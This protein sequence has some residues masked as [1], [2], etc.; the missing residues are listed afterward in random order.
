MPAVSH[1][2]VTGAG[3]AGTATATGLAAAGVA[4]DLIDV[5]P[6]ITAIGSGITMQGNGLRE[7]RRLGVSTPS[8][9]RATPSTAWDCAPPTRPARCSPRYPTHGPAAPTCLPRSACHGPHWR[10]SW[11]TV[12]WR[13]A[14]GCGS[15]PRSARCCRTAAA[16]TC[17]SPM[18]RPDGTTVVG[19]TDQVRDPADDRRDRRAQADRHGHL[20]SVR[21]P[22]RQRHQD[23]P[24]LRRPG[25]IAGYCPTGENSLYA[26]VV[27]DAQDRSALA[28]AGRRA[29]MRNLSE[30][31]TAPGTRSARR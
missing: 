30:A 26:Y 15:A 28:P 18:A 13:P 3:L 19:P 20:P 5:K 22:A 7:L 23:R 25:V 4:V 29:A 2:L 10:G 16:W 24:V 21:A 12:R 17:C 1:V 9:T 31:C 11:P 14:P 6:E 8:S 27:E